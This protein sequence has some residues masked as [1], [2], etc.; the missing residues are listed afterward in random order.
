MKRCLGCTTWFP[1]TDYARIARGMSRFCDQCRQNGLT[2]KMRADSRRWANNEY[3]W[4]NIEAIRAA[5]REY[6]RRRAA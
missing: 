1:E 6:Q 5:D 2:T 4:R 3:R